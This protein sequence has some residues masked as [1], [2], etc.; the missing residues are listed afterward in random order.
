MNEPLA[1]GTEQ[2]DSLQ[3]LSGTLAEQQAALV[4]ALVAGA[5]APAGFDAADISA[6]AHALLHKRAD[7]VARRFPLL[8]HACGGDFPAKFMQWAS[9]RPK[10]S[11]AADAAAFA[12][13]L[14]LPPPGHASR[15]PL[16]RWRKR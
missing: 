12:A 14:G 3:N 15:N 7:E 10:S 9:T 4:R 16:H 6:T 5:P 11:T 13:A 2:R 8:A 1:N